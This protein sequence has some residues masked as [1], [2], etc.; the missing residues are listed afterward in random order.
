MCSG[1]TSQLTLAFWIPRLCSAPV[2]HPRVIYI[3]VTDCFCCLRIMEADL[4]VI[5]K[6]GRGYY[7]GAYALQ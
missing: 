5:K 2:L 1:Q 4:E 6:E 3:T 7:Y